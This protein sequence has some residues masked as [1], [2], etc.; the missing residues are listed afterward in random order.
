MNTN[1]VSKAVRDVND[2][3]STDGL[4]VVFEGIDAVGKTTLARRL[5]E[6]LSSDEP[7]TYVS[8]FSP[9]PVGDLLREKLLEGNYVDTREEALTISSLVVADHF[10]QVEKQIRPA[11]EQGHVLVKD[12]YTPTVYAY[13][14]IHIVDSYGKAD[15]TE[16]YF[17]AV[18]E[19]TPIAPDIVFY[20]DV[21]P[22]VQR[23]RLERRGDSPTPE[24]MDVFERRRELIEQWLESMDS[25]VVSHT[26]DCEIEES[27]GELAGAIEERLRLSNQSQ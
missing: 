27:I 24:D 13:E 22:D 23:T 5:V 12:R 1:V 19:L 17:D 11:L 2:L 20:L 3:S 18:G 9:S 8:E 16:D 10:Y 25:Q 26:T 6:E 15:V 21:P 14:S 4:F 7:V